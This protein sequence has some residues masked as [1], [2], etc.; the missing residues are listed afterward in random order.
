VSAE[1]HYFRIGLFVIVGFLLGVA[2]I[3]VFGGMELEERP[4]VT[5]ETYLSESVQ[6]LEVGSDVKMLGVDLG[7][8][9]DVGFVSSRYPDLE[10]ET[11]LEYGNHIYVRFT[12]Y[13][14]ALLRYPR[15]EFE[16]AVRER[17]ERGMRVQ[18]ASQGIT[19]IK[20]LEVHDFDAAERPV[21]EPPWTPR[22]FYLPSTPGAF[23]EIV[24]SIGDLTDKLGNLSIDQ[25]ASEIQTLVRALKEGIEAAKI[26]EIGQGTNQVLEDIHRILEGEDLQATLANLREVTESSKQGMAKLDRLVESEKVQG[27]VANLHD[28][29]A[30]MK[31]AM[32]KIPGTI[33]RLEEFLAAGQP[34]MEGLMSELR[35]TVR[36]L[37][38]LTDVAKRYPASL[39]FGEM[40]EPASPQ[41]GD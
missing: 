11:L 4:S 15:A 19:G 10:R 25:M 16:A 38:E 8:V 20:Y 34:D 21:F 39:V 14:H 27:S 24:D 7:R 28:A 40:P 2:A 9:E 1:V 17:I 29:T 33:A 31:E 35:M 5:F 18:L 36:N 26:G 41:G 12:V 13:P 30:G 23:T 6:G 3:I 37:R 32:E 22:D